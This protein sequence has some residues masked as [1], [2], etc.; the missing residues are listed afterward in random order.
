ML[1]QFFLVLSLLC[2]WQTANAHSGG[3]G[4]VTEKQAIEIASQTASQFVSFDPG[5]GFGKLDASWNRV[6]S[7]NKQVYKTGDGYY[8]ISIVNPVEGKTLYVLVSI[9]GEVYDANFTGV[10]PGLK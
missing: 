6:P 1:K 3:H 4:P 10:F 8:I 5:L 7:D 9:G 2:V